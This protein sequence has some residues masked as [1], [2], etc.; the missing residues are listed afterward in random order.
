[1]H[2]DFWISRWQE[3]RTGFHG[4]A[5]HDHLVRFEDAFLSGG[6]H[7]VLVPLCGKTIDLD[8]LGQQ[9][10]EVVGI[11]LSP[12]A[13]RAVMTRQTHTFATDDLGPFRR[14]QGGRTTLLEGNVFGATPELLGSFDR[15][16]DRA[17]LVAL[18]PEMRPRYT[19]TLRALLTPGGLLLQNSFAYDQSK[20]NGPPFSVP[21]EE[22][23]EHYV[24]WS[25]ER[26]DQSVMSE[27]KFKERGIDSFE[28]TLTLLGKPA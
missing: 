14:H 18:P 12:V 8:W 3:G 6:P 17:A 1:M 13:T 11:E 9:G 21:T 15:I 24:G 10:H 20:M 22:V 28:I 7:R 4:A 27:G 19:R 5:V 2:P 23:A 16:W 26:L 25:A